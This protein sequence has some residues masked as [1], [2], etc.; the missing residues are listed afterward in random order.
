MSGENEELSPLQKV[1][2]LLI[3]LGA[4]TATE[5]LKQMDEDEAEII[6]EAIARMETVTSEQQD[7]VLNEFEQLLRGGR[8]ISE[9]GVGFARDILQS[10]VGERKAEKILGRLGKKTS[11][12]FYLLRH[13]DPRQLIP[14]I[15]K[16][17]PQTIALILSQ[18]AAEQAAGVFNNL[19]DTLRS[20]V[21][22]R[23]SQLGD[24][25]PETLQELEESLA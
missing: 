19:P 9:G 24:V 17:Q 16:E 3:A 8:F 23:M 20:D 2:V 22:Y 5:I 18:L 13:V 10:A 21:A 14:Y 1:A 7:A 4:E 15:T 11:N 25:A 12:G 6:V